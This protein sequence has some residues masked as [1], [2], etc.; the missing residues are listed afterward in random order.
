MNQG[1]L[2]TQQSADQRMQVVS[3]AWSVA[4]TVYDWLCTLQA[5]IIMSDQYI[6]TKVLGSVRQPLD[7]LYIPG[8]F[9]FSS[10]SVS[11]LHML[12]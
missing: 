7:I 9:S 8:I 6:Y 2:V 10:T 3:L 11:T 5:Q 4:A 1:I 12:T